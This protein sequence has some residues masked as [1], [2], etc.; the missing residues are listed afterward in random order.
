MTVGL[1]AKLEPSFCTSWAIGAG[2]NTLVKMG[3]ADLSAEVFTDEL[4]GDSF[5][6]WG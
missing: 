4:L 3:N 1:D 2:L 6:W 5:I